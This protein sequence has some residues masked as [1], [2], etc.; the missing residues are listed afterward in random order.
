MARK[1]STHE[2]DVRGSRA[3]R[4]NVPKLNPNTPRPPHW[5]DLLGDKQAARDAASWWR[6]TVPELE[7]NGMLTRVDDVVVV[8]CA[9]CWARV[10]QCERELGRT[11]L[12]IVGQKGNL[13]RNPVSLTLSSY[14]QSLK[15]YVQVLGLSPAARQGMDMP[16]RGGGLAVHEKLALIAA[17]EDRGITVT[18]SDLA[19]D[20]W[21]LAGLVPDDLCNQYTRR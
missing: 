7:R 3:K 2:K 10:R 15:T 20:D 6:S 13:V 14:R 18:L 4:K 9:V 5:A 17:C 11:G 1:L 16:D 21:D 8:E 12:L 19:G